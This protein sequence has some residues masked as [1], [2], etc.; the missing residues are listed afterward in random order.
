VAASDGSKSLATIATADSRRTR[1]TAQHGP[2]GARATVQ[3]QTPIT[4]A[5]ATPRRESESVGNFDGKDPGNHVA[6]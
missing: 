6:K 5:I 4:F 2:T 3:V 1:P